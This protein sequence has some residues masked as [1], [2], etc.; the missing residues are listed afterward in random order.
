MFTKKV[1]RRE[2]D[3][4][5]EQISDFVMKLYVILE[6]ILLKCRD[7]SFMILSY[8]PTKAQKSRS[9]PQRS[10]KKKSCPITLGIVILHLL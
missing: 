3:N 1:V 8:G 6:V 10:L 5:K 7:P 9:N 2:I 4:Y